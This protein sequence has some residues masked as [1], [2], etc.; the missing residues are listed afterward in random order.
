MDRIQICD[1]KVEASRVNIILG[2]PALS[3]PRARATTKG[4]REWTQSVFAQLGLLHYLEETFGFMRRMT[5]RTREKTDLN[6]GLKFL[7]I[8]D[9]LEHGK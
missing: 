6:V 8:P 2:A 3:I 1:P 5:W 9:A 4:N 7:N